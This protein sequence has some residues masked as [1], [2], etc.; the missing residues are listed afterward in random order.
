MVA[1]PIEEMPMRFVTCLLLLTLWAT[2]A[3][4]ADAPPAPLADLTVPAAGWH[5]IWHDEF[6]GASLDPTK[7]S[8]GLP[9]KGDDGTD[10]H[11]N[12]Q[13]LSAVTDAD[14]TVHDGLLSL[15]S[16]KVDVAGGRGNTYHYT[17]GF[18]HTNGKFRYT[19][20]YAEA[21]CRS[22]AEGPG[23]WPA[24]WTLTDGWPPENDVVELWSSGHMH[25]GFAYRAAPTT[26]PTGGRRRSQVVWVSHHTEAC[27]PGWH[28]YGLEWGPGFER[29]TFDGRV[30]DTV[31]GP[32][33][34]SRPMYLMLNSGVSSDRGRAPTPDSRWP[35]TFDVDWVRVWQLPVAT[36]R[37][38]GS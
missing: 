24:F 17:E 4:A 19:Y 15:A 31:H 11:H 18:I 9:F 3:S 38:A 23:F 25:Q 22:T 27:P 33:V 30:T 36:T 32:M 28:T 29:F 8:S 20:G 10:R 12:A 7:W 35:M 2:T 16:R 34:P 14:V 21:R 5:L 13:Y 26:A 37:P 6:D 1:D